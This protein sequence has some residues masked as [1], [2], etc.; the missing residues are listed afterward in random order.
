M[1]VMMIGGCSFHGEMIRAIEFMSTARMDNN[2]KTDNDDN[3][4]NDAANERLDVII[5]VVLG[6][7]NA[8]ASEGPESD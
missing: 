5:Q 3:S 1:T 6:K 2:N 7:V 4:N 8:S